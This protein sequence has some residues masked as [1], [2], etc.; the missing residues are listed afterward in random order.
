MRRGVSGRWRIWWFF[1]FEIAHLQYI[2]QDFC[3]GSSKAP[4]FCSFSMVL[5]QILGLSPHFQKLCKGIT[6]GVKTSLFLQYEVDL[7]TKISCQDLKNV[8]SKVLYWFNFESH[9]IENSVSQPTNW[10][11]ALALEEVKRYLSFLLYQGRLPTEYCPPTSSKW[12]IQSAILCKFSNISIKI[13]VFYPLA[14]NARRDC[15]VRTIFCGFSNLRLLSWRIS[16]VR[17]VKTNYPSSHSYALSQL[18]FLKF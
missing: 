3:N 6:G 4:R 14:K 18:F 2:N 12:A 16:P 1:L 9:V 13:R 7:M 15:Y 5:I 11:C 17:F 8:S 10:K